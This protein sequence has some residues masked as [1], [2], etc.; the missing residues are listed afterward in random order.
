[1]ILYEYCYERA[2]NDAWLKDYVQLHRNDCGLY[3][4]HKKRWSGWSGD[5]KENHT[6]ELDENDLE[7][8]QKMIDEYI[9]EHSLYEKHSNGK[10]EGIIIK[11][12]ELIN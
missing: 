4:D 10:E 6:L 1:M 11:L 2:G 8:S 3:L 7:K 9:E 12:T 5:I